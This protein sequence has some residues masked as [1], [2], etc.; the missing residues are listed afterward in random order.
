MPAGLQPVQPA[1]PQLTALVMQ[2]LARDPADRPA[3]MQDVIRRLQS[4][5][6]DARGVEPGAGAMIEEASE[7]VTGPAQRAARRWPRSRVVLFG[8]AASVAALAVVLL[9]RARSGEPAPAAI[10]VELAPVTDIGSAIAPASDAAMQSADAELERVAETAREELA[11]E[12]RDG[13]AALAAGQVALARAAFERALRV[14]PQD[15]GAT[16]GL[17]EAA[18]LEQVLALHSDA[19]RAEAAGQLQRA[20]ELF[21]SA[22]RLDGSFAPAA[23]GLDRVRAAQQDQQVDV[24][25]RSGTVALRAGQLDTA[26]AE[27]AEAARLRPADARAREG[28]AGVADARRRL[29]DERDLQAG[30]DLE[31][32]ERWVEAVALYESVVARDA[33]LDFARQGLQRSRARAALAQ[34]LDDFA[35][36]PERLSAAAVRS[37]AG[38]A[39]AR[40]AAIGGPAPVLEAQAARVRELLA[41]YA[42]PAHIAISSDNS[43]RIF[44]AHVGDLGAF[45][46][47]ELSLPPGRYTVIGTRTGFRD[48]RRELNIAPGQRH[49]ELS[50]QCTE[51]I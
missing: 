49:V 3:D 25:L 27:F 20:A 18:R 9:V 48:V 41:P 42:V 21:A 47:R 43:T 36:R 12:I 17:A 39:I 15:P 10:S 22:L 6:P 31:R 24:A 19:I 1:P 40:A 8:V 4:C 50:V 14:Q 34:Q 13:R 16:R 45:L 38:Q 46:S 32:R 30:I 35:A 51:R 11:R 37:S 33:K 5:L 2:M 29:Q 7:P 28:M 26:Q 23:A 44:I